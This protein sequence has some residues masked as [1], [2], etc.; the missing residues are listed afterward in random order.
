MV[1]IIKSINKLIKLTDKINSIRLDTEDLDMDSIN[2][3]TRNNHVSIK[4][5]EDIVRMFYFWCEKLA[6]NISE[7]IKHDYFE[8]RRLICKVSP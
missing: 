1:K 6:Y 2:H 7:D 8:T 3:F 4:D 5:V